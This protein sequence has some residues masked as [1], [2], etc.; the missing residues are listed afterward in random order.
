MGTDC[1]LRLVRCALN[2]TPNSQE[3][4]A[5]E[6]SLAEEDVSKYPYLRLLA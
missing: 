6:M 5:V 2:G 1:E 3:R 4:L